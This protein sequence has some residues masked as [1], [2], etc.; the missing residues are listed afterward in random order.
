[1]LTPEEVAQEWIDHSGLSALPSLSEIRHQLQRYGLAIH[2]TDTPGLRGHNYCYRGGDHTLFY[3]T[4][5]WRG[6]VEFTLLHEFYEIIL[7]SLASIS[8]GQA[9]LPGAEVCWRANSFAASVLMQKDIFL[10]ALYESHFDIVW[11][12]R[13][14][15]RSYSAIAIRAMEVLNGLEPG[16]RK[17]L[18]C[19]IYQRDGD[20][21]RWEA[22]HD[23][24]HGACAAYTSGLRH[25]SKGQPAHPLPKKKDGVL[26]GSIVDLV[27]HTGKPVLVEEAT[28]FDGAGDGAL[29]LLARPVYWFRRPAKVILEGMRVQDSHV[30]QAQSGPLKPTVV[31]QTFQLSMV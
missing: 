9:T 29:T 15:Y 16:T 28:G 20:P 25:V 27:L 11:L 22:G 2:T 3:E 1:M 6:S 14:F 19:V 8:R 13:H 23:D 31:A 17:E 21:A 4:D 5:E 26:P 24:L 7:D 10:R 30:L 12:H 18:A